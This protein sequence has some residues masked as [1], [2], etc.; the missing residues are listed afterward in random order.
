[1]VQL[2]QIM[3]AD[4]VSNKSAAQG[5]IYANDVQFNSYD[6]PGRYI[7]LHDKKSK[8][9]WSASWQPVG[10]SLK[11]YKSECRHGT[12]YT[13]ISSEY[14]KIKTESLYFVPLYRT[15]EIWYLKVMNADKKKRNLSVFTFVEYTNNWKLSQDLNNLQY[16]QYIVK[17]DVVDNI[18]DHGQMFICL[19]CLN[20]LKMMDKDGTHF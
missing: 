5:Q 10:K 11:K 1:M 7:Y 3:P 18:I 13:K 9:Y 19:Q 12:A 6:Q 16:S 15:D 2:L 20:I 14:S 17:M 8:D 4:I